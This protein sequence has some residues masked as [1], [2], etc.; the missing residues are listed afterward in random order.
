MQSLTRPPQGSLT[1][2]TS[3]AQDRRRRPHPP[4]HGRACGRIPPSP[5]PTGPGTAGLTLTVRA[6]P[7]DRGPLERY[8]LLRSGIIRKGYPGYA[9][10]LKKAPSWGLLTADKNQIGVRSGV[11]QTAQGPG[12]PGGN[13]EPEFLSSEPQSGC[14][15]DGRRTGALPPESWGP[16]EPI[17]AGQRVKTAGEGTYLRQNSRAASGKRPGQ[18][19]GASPPVE[20]TQRRGP[21]VS[22]SGTRVPRGADP[23]NP[24]TSESELLL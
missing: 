24:F 21:R 14:C 17:A 19:A 5:A 23:K 7:G 18:A 20:E 3:S 2:Q 4:H 1:P 12:T 10:P 6:P 9:G 8:G 11:P 13:L 22:G 16:V 15:R